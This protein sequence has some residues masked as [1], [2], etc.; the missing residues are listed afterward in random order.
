MRNYQPICRSCQEAAVKP[1]TAAHNPCY[2]GRQLVIT[3][4]LRLLRAYISVWNV[5]F[6]VYF[7]YSR[8][9][10][11]SHQGVAEGGE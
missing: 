11:M 10:L 5:F 4:R 6:A 7:G 3:V 1:R 8:K 9:I 2:E